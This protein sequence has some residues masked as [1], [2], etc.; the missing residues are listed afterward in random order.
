MVCYS[1]VETRGRP[2][3]AARGRLRLM[4]VLQGFVR[5]IPEPRLDQRDTNLRRLVM[6][7]SCYV[8]KTTIFHLDVIAESMIPASMLKGEPL[9]CSG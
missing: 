4:S 5:V 8:I 2:E 3:I 7:G 1:I 6:P 9:A